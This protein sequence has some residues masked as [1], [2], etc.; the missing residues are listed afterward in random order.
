M[1]QFFKD[2]N[3]RQ[4]IGLII[5]LLV[6]PMVSAA[7]AL[8]RRGSADRPEDIP[9]L[10]ARLLSGLT[11]QLGRSTVTLLTD[12]EQ[13]LMSYP[14]PRN[15]REL[16]NVLERAVLLSDCDALDRTS[17]RLQ[18]SSG[19]EVIGG[20]N[21]VEPLKT[22]LSKVAQQFP[23]AQSLPVQ[24]ERLS[25]TLIVNLFQAHGTP[26]FDA[27]YMCGVYEH[28]KG[29][30]VLLDPEKLMLS[31]E[32]QQ[33]EAASTEANNRGRASALPFDTQAN[34]TSTP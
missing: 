29:L 10:A 4:K 3:V 19:V 27:P 31:P 21:L 7:F 5:I 16:R 23:T 32:M 34:L 18:A 11:A 9:L 1:L 13:A 17:L 2:L 24:D 14:F 20:E 30:V 22:I 12:A 8:V 15:V 25:A 33:F 6:I 28:D 26:A